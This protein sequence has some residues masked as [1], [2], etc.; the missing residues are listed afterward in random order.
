MRSLCLN[1]AVMTEIGIKGQSGL[2]DSIYL[3]PIVKHFSPK[4]DKV[5]V[6][7]NYPELFGSIE[8]VTC[9]RHLKLN[10]VTEET[11]QREIPIS[12][13]ASYAGGKHKPGTSQFE[14]YCLFSGITDKLNLSLPWTIKNKDLESVVKNVAKGRK[15]SIVAAPYQPF[16]RDDKWGNELCINPESIQSIIDKHN[17]EFLFIAVGNKYCLDKLSIE[18]DLIDKTTIPDLLDLVKMSDICISQ[19]GNMLPMAECMGKKNLIIFADYTRKI[20]EPYR[21]KEESFLSAITPEKCVHYKHLNKSVY[22]NEETIGVFR[23]L[24][25]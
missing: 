12:V 24:C 20:K 10:H 21:S 25:R 4:F 6:M 3:Y 16:G 13:R 14:D 19:I 7:T 5:H 22:D 8:N 9:Y 15:I 2:G 17:K 11:T 18:Y 23:E 1:G